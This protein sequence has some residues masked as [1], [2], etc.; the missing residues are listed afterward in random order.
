MASDQK[1]IKSYR[2]SSLLGFYR[3]KFERS[4]T[5]KYRRFE[6]CN[7]CAIEVVSGI[8]FNGYAY[9]GYA[10]NGY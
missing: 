2:P 9:N 3:V 5:N 1:N 6:R 4:L 7:F 8:A 10:Y